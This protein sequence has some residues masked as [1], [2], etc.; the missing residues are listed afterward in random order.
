M[1]F[2]KALLFTK[3]RA[4]ISSKSEYFL[5]NM[6]FA[7]PQFFSLKWKDCCTRIPEKTTM[8]NKIISAFSISP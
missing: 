8:K 3:R 1:I 5:E 2:R 6:S 7:H 4:K